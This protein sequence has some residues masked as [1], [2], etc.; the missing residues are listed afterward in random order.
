[1]RA[2]DSN[3]LVRLFTGDDKRQC[4]AAEQ[5]IARGAWVPTLAVAETL[6]VLRQGYGFAAARLADLV[7]M[8][9]NHESLV[10][11][12]PDLIAE[13]LTMFRAEPSLGFSDCLM[14]AA[15]RAAGHLPLGTFDRKLSRI[16][17]AQ[18]L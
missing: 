5:Y 14:L 4:A 12:D 8:L 10:L 1:M 13:S 17:G 15:A 9:L 11:E 6:W 2:V 18:R 16:D 3:V 7:E